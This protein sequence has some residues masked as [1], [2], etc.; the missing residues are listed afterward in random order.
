MYGYM[1]IDGPSSEHSS[2]LNAFQL[3]FSFY[4]VIF[5]CLLAC[6]IKI[7]LKGSLNIAKNTIL[8]LTV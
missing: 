3:S 5:L 7:K 4:E 6:L 2:T 8:S 1:Y